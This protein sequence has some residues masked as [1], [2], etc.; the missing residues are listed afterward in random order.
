[1]DVNGDLAAGG[2]QKKKSRALSVW[3]DAFVLAA[4]AFLSLHTSAPFRAVNVKLVAT[5]DATA[6]AA[7][8]MLSP[9]AQQC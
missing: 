7:I 9:C 4:I 3:I 8:L 5:V 1:M 6:R 2:E